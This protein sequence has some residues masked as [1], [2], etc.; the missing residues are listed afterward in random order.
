M[1]MKDRK[2][3]IM[4]EGSPFPMAVKYPDANIFTPDRRKVNANSFS[5]GTPIPNM[6]GSSEKKLI[7]GNAKIMH[8]DVIVRAK[9]EVRAVAYKVVSFN[10]FSFPAP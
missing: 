4:A 5:A 10:F 3:E 8:I 7:K 9:I 1:H 6:R 2:N